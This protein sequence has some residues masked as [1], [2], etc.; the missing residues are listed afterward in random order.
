MEITESNILGKIVTLSG[1]PVI[2]KDIGEY[3]FIDASKTGRTYGPEFNAISTLIRGIK[4][5]GFLI[6]SICMI[7]YV[8][9]S[10][11]DSRRAKL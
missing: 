2:I 3:F 9:F 10:L 4:F 6:F 11:R 5:A 8:V 1:K 7:L